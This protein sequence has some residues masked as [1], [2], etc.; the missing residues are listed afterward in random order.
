VSLQIPIDKIGEVI[1]PK[2]KVINTLQQETGA[3]I[4]VDDDGVVGTVT[5]GAKDGRAVE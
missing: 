2:G 5:I 1:G 3:D 4:A